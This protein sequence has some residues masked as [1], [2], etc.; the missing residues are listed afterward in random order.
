MEE[1]IAGNILEC[2]GGTPLVRIRGTEEGGAEVL[3]KPEG[4]NP[5]GS[6]KDRA[7]LS[8]V[9]AAEASGAL[10]PGGTIV[11]PTS[12]NSGIGLAMMAAVKKYRLVLTMPASMSVER[13]QA[14]AAY[15]AEVVL[16]P[17]TAGMAGAIARAKEIAEKE[18][19]AWMPGQ[20]DNPAN[21]E[22]HYRTTAEEILRDCGGRVDAFVAGVGTGG[23]VSGVGRRLKEAV[24]GV[25][26]IAV[27]PEE[28][29]VLSGGN[30]GSHRLQGIG[31]GFVPSI[32]DWSVVDRIFTVGAES[33]GQTTLWLAREH[34]ILAGISSGAAAYAAMTM[35]QWEAYEGKRIVVL[36]PDT[37]LRY[38]SGWPFGRG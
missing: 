2:I 22:A 14:L 20:F 28:S 30:P 32:F 8:M 17:G 33:A 11:E 25:R 16:T 1:R 26:I 21:L 18:S 29:A 5:G 4:M 7:A 31:A 6:S 37:G 10:R 34:G 24:E 38:L 15:G 27:E 3:A 36:L 35:A 9:E 23:T 12:G 13:Q 19:G